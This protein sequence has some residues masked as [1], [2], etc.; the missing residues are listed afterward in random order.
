MGS[1]YNAKC[2]MN[3]HGYLDVLKSSYGLCAAKAR[4]SSHPLSRLFNPSIRLEHYRIYLGKA[5]K[6]NERLEPATSL[7]ISLNGVYIDLS[8]YPT[9]RHWQP[10]RLNTSLLPGRNPRKG[11]RHNMLGVLGFLKQVLV[12]I[13]TYCPHYWS[14]DYCRSWYNFEISFR[15]IIISQ[16]L[17]DISFPSVDVVNYNVLRNG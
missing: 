10:D 16:Q 1:L 17:L 5:K 14:R 7:R 9:V 3:R 4:S 2:V 12:I 15:F 6:T 8:R 11:L 13:Y